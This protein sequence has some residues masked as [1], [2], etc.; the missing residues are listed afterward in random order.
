MA[1]TDPNRLLADRI[2]IERAAYLYGRAL[3]SRDAEGQKL[4]KQCMLPDVEVE[5]FFGK[6]Q[7]VEEHMKIHRATVQQN[8]TM[9]QHMLSNPLIEISGDTAT[10]EW[11]VH[12]VH[13]VK[14]ESGDRIVYAGAIYRQ[15]LVRTSEG[16]RIKRHHC[17]T[18]WEDDGGKLLESC[19]ETFDSTRKRA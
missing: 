12:A 2:G 11:Y 9:T 1:H 15:D 13:G 3:D 18:T 8:F 10:A 7:G 5:Y 16:W 6:W 19:Q 17:T 14:S 4:F